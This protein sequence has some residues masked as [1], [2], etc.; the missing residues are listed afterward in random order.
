MLRAS[1]NPKY[2]YDE[3]WTDLERCLLL[4]GYR[5]IGDYSNAYKVVAV[6]PTIA[7]AVPSEDDLSTELRR[8]NLAD[9]EEVI[10]LMSNSANDFCKQPPDFNGSLTSAR[11]SLETLAKRVAAV[12]STTTS[13]SGDPLKF[14][15]VVAYLRQINFLD[16]KKKKGLR[17]CMHS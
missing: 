12:R 15:A 4:D 7:G 10:R 1:I 6:D 8:S 5:V 3:R 11:V 14:G 17:V 16:E 13:M 2:L 9:Y